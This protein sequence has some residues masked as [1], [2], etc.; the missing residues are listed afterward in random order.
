M[1]CRSMAQSHELKDELETPKNEIA[2]LL[3]AKSERV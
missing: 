2:D 3:R 1:E